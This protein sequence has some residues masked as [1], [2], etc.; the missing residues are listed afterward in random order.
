MAM[1]TRDFLL[2]K[3]VVLTSRSDPIADNE[4]TLSRL[5]REVLH[6]LHKDPMYGPTH[7]LERSKVGVEFERRLEETL[8][9]MGACQ[10]FESSSVS[11]LTIFFKICHLRRKN[12]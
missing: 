1:G 2:L 7:D 12:S 5:A 6:V 8:K 10:A 11:D 3:L 4:H 9:W